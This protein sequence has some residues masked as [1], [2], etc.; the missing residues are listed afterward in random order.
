MRSYT[1]RI[2]VSNSNLIMSQIIMSEI[3]KLLWDSIG[4]ILLASYNYSIETAKKLNRTARQGII[5]LLPKGDKDPTQIKNWR[6]LTL[7][8]IDYKILSRTMAL[9]LKPIL[10]RIIGPHQTGFL[11]NRQISDNIRK[12]ID[13]IA[14]ANR[15]GRLRQVIV[16]IDFNKCFDHVAYED[17][18]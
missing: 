5:S 9:R 13:V 14:Q 11:E 10:D 16:T 8:N 6:P 1:Q 17:E 7:L 2:K 3:Y 18:S 12:T 4:S 15:N